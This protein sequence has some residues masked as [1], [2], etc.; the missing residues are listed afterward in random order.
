MELNRRRSR[1]SDFFVTYYDK[2]SIHIVYVKGLKRYYLLGNTGQIADSSVIY[3]LTKEDADRLI[4]GKISVSDIMK[5][6]GR[7]LNLSNYERCFSEE[8]WEELARLA[9]QDNSF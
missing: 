3:S 5:R 8:N 7:G 2:N 9:D 1:L 4:A 6:E